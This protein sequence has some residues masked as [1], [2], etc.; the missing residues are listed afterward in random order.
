MRTRT[1]KICYARDANASVCILVVDGT[2]ANVVTYT[3]NARTAS[4]GPLQKRSMVCAAASA[5]MQLGSIRNKNV[6]STMKFIPRKT[7]AYCKR[8]TLAWRFK[9]GE[10]PTCNKNNKK[11]EDV[12]C[13]KCNVVGTH[14][15]AE[16]WACL[17]CQECYHV[18]IDNAVRTT[19]FLFSYCDI[20]KTGDKI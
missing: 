15:V 7:C 8:D 5:A 16:R 11:H 12:A 20:C 10:C 3:I 18:C 19:P 14:Y 1:F 17:D 2:A 13:P 6:I 9:W 4:C